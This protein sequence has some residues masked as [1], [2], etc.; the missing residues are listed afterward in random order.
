MSEQ[1]SIISF[2]R[3]SEMPKTSDDDAMSI[4]E[5]L[6]EMVEELAVDMRQMQWRL[7]KLER[8]FGATG[9]D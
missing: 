7:T 9:K 5:S 4:L 2:E 1:D 8:Q 3:R 6:R